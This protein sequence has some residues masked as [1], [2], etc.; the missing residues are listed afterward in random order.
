MRKWF[1]TAAIAVALGT[2]MMPARAEDF[3]WN[4]DINLK[5]YAD[6]ANWH[7]GSRTPSQPPSA[8]DDI[9]SPLLYS[10]VSVA[11][12]QEVKNFRVQLDKK[13]MLIGKNAVTFHGDFSKG[14]QE[15]VIRDG[16]R[17]DIDFDVLIEGALTLESGFLRFGQEAEHGE[18]NSLIVNGETLVRDGSLLFRTTHVRLARGLTIEGGTVAVYQG[19]GPGGITVAGIKGAA[20][21]ILA[22]TSGTLIPDA[23]ITVDIPDGV[24]VFEGNLQDGPGGSLSLV[25]TG[26][27]T[28]L[29]SGSENSFSKGVIIRQGTVIIENS[30]ASALGSGPVQVRETGVLAGYGLIDGP[31]EL[32]GQ[33]VLSPGT[34]SDKVGL[35]TFRQ[36]LSVLSD[37]ATIHLH[38][39]DSSKDTEELQGQGT[40]VPGGRLLLEVSARSQR[41]WRIFSGFSV[42]PNRHFAAVALDGGVNARLVR[43]GNVWSAATAGARW[44]FDETSGLLSCTP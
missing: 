15:L 22:S 17:E 26:S 3:A 36:G 9:V 4:T 28:Q 24:A 7:V 42:Q 12:P 27:G 43:N 30:Q 21:T 44:T 1:E 39:G 41:S 29:L 25:K 31:V 23:V 34:A 33:A 35:V 20:G 18:L 14:G 11:G 40:F 10:I 8:A 37:T 6:P 32:S 13:W 19:Q 16:G 38:L 5:L 2:A